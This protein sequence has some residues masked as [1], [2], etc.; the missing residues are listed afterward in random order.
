MQKYSRVNNLVGWVVFAVAAV[1]YWLTLE[2]TVSFWDCGEFISS[3]YK[4]E[5]GHPP[6]APFFMILARLFSL[7]AS[8]PQN[9]ALM[10]NALSGLASAFTVLFLFWTITHLALKMTGCSKDKI[11]RDQMLAIMGAG[12]VGALAYA[13]SD[14]FWFSAVE[15]EVYACSS[16]FTAL[17]FWAILKWEG[18]AKTPY[19]NRWIILI[20]Y[21]MGLSI[22]V[23]LLN[24]LAIPSMVMVYYFANYKP[25]V[26]GVI[27]AGVTAIVLLGGVMYGVIPGVVKV[28]SWFELLSVNGLGCP[29]NTGVIVFAVLMVGGVIAGI[30]YTLKHK[31]VLANT[32]LTAFTVIMIGYSSF[33][34]IVIRSSANPPLDENNPDN[35]FSMLSYL[36]REQYGDRPLFNGPSFNTPLVESDPYVE[37]KPL[38]VKRNGRYEVGYMQQKLNYD[39]NY[40]TIFPRLYSR[41]KRHIK[42]YVKWAGVKANQKSTSLYDNL[43]FFF[44]YQLNHMYFR[45]FMWNFAGRQD[46]I[47]SHGSVSHGNWIC[48]IPFI[49]NWRVGDQQDLPKTMKQNKG[50]NRYYLLPLLLGLL[51]MVVHYRSGAK[52]RRDF[53]VVMLLFVFTGVAIVVYLNQ[54]PLQPR[55]RDYAYVGSFYAF[56]IWIGLGVM[57]LWKII[58]KVIPS[59]WGAAMAG[60]IS[61]LAV[62]SV[63]AC[64]NWDDHDRSN[65]FTAR[66]LAYDYLQSCA[67]NAILFTLGD[68]DTFPLWYLQEVEG[69][70]TDVRVCNLSYLSADWYIDQ[71]K[72]QAYASSPLPI[73][74]KREQY[75]RGVREEIY[76]VDNSR[77]KKLVKSDGGI[78]LGDG[79][80]YVA[81]DNPD[82]KSIPG[83]D[84]RID[85]FPARK[86][87]LPINKHQILSTAT[88]SPCDT[89][90][91]APRMEWSYKKYRLL[92][93]ELMVLDMLANNHW[94]RPI[95]F[96][97][98]VGRDNYL[99]LEKY[100]QL[101]GFA[102]RLVPIKTENS[103]GQ[104]GRVKTDVMYDN[105]MHKFR[106]G[107]MNKSGVYLDENNRRMC[108]N[109]RNNFL[110]LSEALLSEGK[111]DSA[112]Q[113]LDRCRELI[114]NNKVSYGYFA[115]LMVRTY[116][117]AGED[118][119]ANKMVEIM[120]HS[121]VE[122]VDYFF[123]Q[124]PY[125]INQSTREQ[126]HNLALLQELLRLSM[127]YKQD[128]LQKTLELDFRRL[129][130]IYQQE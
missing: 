23:H 28:A 37:D 10:I 5:V 43:K 32:L 101:E 69:V 42:E 19:A 45:Y 124:S 11:S 72:R 125:I 7:F 95:Y 74:L 94:E 111:R 84:Q 109:L 127:V 78:L 122:E 120:H 9:V 117:K 27:K 77:L 118:L 63:M 24:L 2:P 98:T 119:K 83:I 29:F 128:K 71:M 121:L 103:D 80:Q 16:L 51:G 106:W 130:K 33:A 108:Q 89:S 60:I 79:I 99:N 50:N 96:A 81:S 13:F 48:G 102:Y 105:F 91:M 93:H 87:I 49:D 26:K 114:P 73:S 17:V 61:L 34:M 53:W 82:T 18:V 22:G 14:T 46:D 3:S 112:V 97:I 41:D 52:G 100:F 54:T 107:N 62:P 35:V 126:G 76:L 40:T 59:F 64:Q 115:L 104:L 86:F 75:E 57:G 66:D 67:P 8:S 92:K 88:L 36:N 70:R 85:H 55:E 65:R 110:R 90:I 25:S 58:G 30:H 39:S 123:T 44:S 47:Q 113:V 15:G 4:L 129:V 12:S 68:N 56:A 20:A 31:L 1:T 21:L 6:G 38:Y 116:Y